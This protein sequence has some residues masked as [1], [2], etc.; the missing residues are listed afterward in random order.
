[1]LEK[2][3]QENKNETNLSLK[4]YALITINTIKVLSLNLEAPSIIMMLKF[5]ILFYL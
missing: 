2:T 1:M 3:Q 4:A 5:L